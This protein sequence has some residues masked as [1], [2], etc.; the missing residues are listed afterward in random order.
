MYIIEKYFKILK[1][2]YIYDIYCYQYFKSSRRIKED[3]SEI[4]DKKPSYFKLLTTLERRLTVR[5]FRH[6]RNM[7]ECINKN[8]LQCINK[9]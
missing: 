2:L 1:Y 9:N 3:Y 7:I 5:C 6:K 8:L 4:D